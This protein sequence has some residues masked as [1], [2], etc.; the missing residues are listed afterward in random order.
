MV[1]ETTATA[2]VLGFFIIKIAIIVVIFLLLRGL[3]LWYLKINA[4]VDL[5]TQQ[6]KNQRLILKHLKGETEEPGK[7]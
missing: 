7:E 3:I 1:G 2:M 4:I 5:L 6:L